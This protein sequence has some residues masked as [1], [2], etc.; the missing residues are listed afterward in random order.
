MMKVED[1]CLRKLFVK[2]LQWPMPSV[3]SVRRNIVLTNVASDSLKYLMLKLVNQ[4]WRVLRCDSRVGAV[5]IH[6]RARACVCVY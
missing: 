6:I 1:H 3:F 5:D 2:Y 4:C